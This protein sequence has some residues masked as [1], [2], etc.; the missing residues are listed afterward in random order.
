MSSAP[1]EEGA[2]PHLLIELF[3]QEV[4]LVIVGLEGPSSLTP[5]FNS[6]PQG[7]DGNWLNERSCVQSRH[8]LEGL[9]RQEIDLVFVCRVCIPTPE[10]NNLCQHLVPEGMLHVKGM[11]ASGAP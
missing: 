11:M 3:R 5:F 1:N 8:S 6:M 9:N 7:K 10:R 2:S 4:D